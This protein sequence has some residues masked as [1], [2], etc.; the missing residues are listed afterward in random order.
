M[1]QHGARACGFESLLE[2]EFLMLADHDGDVAGIASQPFALLWP[3]GTEGAR[4]HVPDFFVRMADG[5]GRV[6]DVRHPKRV[7]A[8]ERQFGLTREVCGQVGWLYEVF[9][10]LAEPF[11]SNLRW[12]AGYRHDRFLPP[13]SMV[14]VILEAFIPGAPLAAG[15]QG[16]ARTLGL[17]PAVVHAHVLHLLFVG[18]LKADLEQPLS[19]ESIVVPGRGPAWDAMLDA[20]S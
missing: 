13:S 11:A 12:L 2:R 20:V 17:D 15:V 4:G 7:A 5:S 14:P 6:V 1:V 18:A 16:A 10:G 9:T 3:K 19:L 8:A